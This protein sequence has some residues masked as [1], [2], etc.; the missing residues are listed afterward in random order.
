MPP[1]APRRER[2]SRVCQTHTTFV[3]S[4]V[5]ICCALAAGQGL[6][7]LLQM[8]WLAL[9]SWN[10]EK[11]GVELLSLRGKSFT[12]G[13]AGVC[14]TVQCS[15]GSPAPAGGMC[16]LWPSLPALLSSSTPAPLQEPPVLLCWTW[17]LPWD[18]GDQPGWAET[19]QKLSRLKIYCDLGG[20]FIFELSL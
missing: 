15:W 19:E 4:T 2:F 10:M 3:W 11:D 12:P 1:T 8:D 20:M 16:W 14:Q 18:K 17:E 7:Q 6:P 13:T 5:Y 9:S